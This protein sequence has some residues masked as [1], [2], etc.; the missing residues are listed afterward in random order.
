MLISTVIGLTTMC[1]ILTMEILIEGQKGGR[2]LWPYGDPVPGNYVTKVGFPAFVIMVALAVSIKGRIAVFAGF[3]ALISMV[4][5]VMTGERINFL[6]RACG[7]M[8]AGLVWKPKFGRYLGLVAAKIFA[9]AAVFLIL[10]ATAKRFSGDLLRG[11]TNMAESVWL[12]TVNGGWQLAQDNLMFGIGTGNFSLIAYSG[13]LDGYDNVRPDVHPHN[14]YVQL[15]LETGVIGFVLGV[16]FMWSIVWACFRECLISRANVF[17]ATAWVIP[18]G[19]FWPIATSADFFGQWN[20][21]FF[22]SAIA[23]ALCSTNFSSKLHMFHQNR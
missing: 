10:P 17:V 23:M 11:A 9:V 3:L 18:F 1:G 20:N 5:S 6:I 4:I 21:V 16:I 14:Y 12:K 22:W 8:H 19:I 7:G 15:L 2:L 13:V